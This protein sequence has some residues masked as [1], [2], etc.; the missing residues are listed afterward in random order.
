MDVIFPFVPVRVS[1]APATG[2]GGINPNPACGSSPVYLQGRATAALYNYTPYQPNRAALAGTNDGCG[3]YGNLNFW[4]LYTDWFGSTNGFSVSGVIGDKYIS[5]G[6]ESSWLGLPTSRMSCDP[7]G[8]R[9]YQ[10][11]E[12]GRIYSSPAGAFATREAH[13]TLWGKYPDAMRS[14][15]APTSDPSNTTNTY[16]QT[17]EGGSITVTNGEPSIN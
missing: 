17:Y 10:F 5:L 4:R 6:G 9:C 13:I 15:G 12:N 7:T 16:T 14:L 8:T 11:F 1:Q 2:L 3:A